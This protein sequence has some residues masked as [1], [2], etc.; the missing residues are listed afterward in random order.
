MKFDKYFFVKTIERHRYDFNSEGPKGIIRKIV[1]YD[2]MEFQPFAI[3]TL[4]FGDWEEPTGD[5]NDTVVTNNN[6][7]RKVL[8]TVAATVLQFMRDRPN[9]GVFAQGSTPARNRL[10]Q[11]GIGL[12]WDE[13]KFEMDLFGKLGDLWFKFEKGINYE[14]FTIAPKSMN[15][16]PNYKKL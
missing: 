12:V 3:F 11:M 7:R 14:A 8:T 1:L 13:I 6:D 15:F 2:N 5:I 16:D 9:T 10:Y 4:G